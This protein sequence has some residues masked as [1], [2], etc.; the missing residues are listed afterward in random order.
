MWFWNDTLAFADVRPEAETK[1]NR[2]LIV[3]RNT[4]LSE[5]EGMH[6]YISTTYS[7]ADIRESP[8]PRVSGS[9]WWLGGTHEYTQKPR[10]EYPD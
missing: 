6:Y 1:V 5:N 9:G 4:V 3:Y 8:P 7:V 2:L 10:T